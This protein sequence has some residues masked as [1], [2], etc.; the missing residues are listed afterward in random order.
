MGHE[1]TDEQIAALEVRIHEAYAQAANEMQDRLE[2]WLG[3]FDRDR[4]GWEK[5]VKA[6][7]R[8]KDEYKNWLK[9]M[10]MERTWQENMINQL[11]YDAVNC[12]VLCRQM[13]NDEIPTAFAENANMQA[14][15]IS[16][17]TGMDLSF[18]IYDRDTARALLTD[19][20][21]YRQ[22]NVSDDLAWNRKKFAS[23]MM[24]SVLQ[25]ESIPHTAKRLKG[26]FDMDARASV[27]V[28]RTSMTY[29]EGLGKQNSM[30][31][32]QSMGIPIMQRWN[33]LHDG[34]TRYEH[35][36]M[37]GVTIPVGQKF[38]VDGY[39]MTGPGDPTAPARLVCNCRCNL[40]PE[41]QYDG[42]SPRIA[43]NNDKFP[44]DVSYEDWK[45]G[46]YRTDAEGNETEESK[47]ERYGKDYKARR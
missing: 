42:I 9:D 13:V 17:A 23:A 7:V 22:V 6:G 3:D 18:T 36:Q 28:A 38:N 40:T 2:G 20:E 16:R 10:A 5:A 31:R 37:D 33:A 15:Q 25:G 8:T 41:V 19:P 29:V 46:K 4:E 11:S 24:Q 34:R 14:Y 44:D 43:I 21:I 39:R 35:R 26:V 47:R 1:W 27:M 32:A 12:D 45:S 30:R